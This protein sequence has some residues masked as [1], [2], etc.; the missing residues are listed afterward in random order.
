MLVL[1][2]A[3]VF[4]QESVLDTLKAAI[5]PLPSVV[6]HEQLVRYHNQKLKGTRTDDIHISPAGEETYANISWNGRP[7]ASMDRLPKNALGLYHGMLSAAVA[8]LSAP[9][10]AYVS[11]G[12]NGDVVAQFNTSHE[13]SM[14][15]L[16]GAW[17][18]Y[19]I[20]HTS[21]VVISPD[22]MQITIS[23]R[24][25]CPMPHV[26]RA[27]AFLQ[28]TE[29]VVAGRTLLLP[30]KAWQVVTAWDNSMSRWESTFTDY[31]RFEIESSLLTA[32][33]RP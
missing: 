24:A 26:Q 29:T 32:D 7:V 17:G 6:C 18:A 9:D 19:P 23:N 20:A 15:S 30:T 1:I 25:E 8:A 11:R 31:R 27:E 3:L 28:L 21:V 5:T 14:W 10:R 13:Q 22:Q 12:V 33:A 2:A 16:T 4:T